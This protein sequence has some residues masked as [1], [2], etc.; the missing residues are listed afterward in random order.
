MNTELSEL[1]KLMQMQIKKKKPG[2]KESGHLPVCAI[3][4]WILFIH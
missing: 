4:S 3:S 2:R 1:N